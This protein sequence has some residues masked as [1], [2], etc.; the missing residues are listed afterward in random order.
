MTRI[1]T[2]AMLAA[3]TLPQAHRHGINAFA[4][5]RLLVD[6]APYPNMG[7]GDLIELFWNN[8]FAASRCL[9]ATDIGLSSHLRVPQSFVQNGTARL[10]YR[11]MQV[12]RGAARSAITRVQVKT[13]Y[14]GGQP[15]ALCGEENQNLAPVVLPE[16]IRRHGVNS[17]QIRRGV[18]LVIEPYLNMAAGDDITL[19]WGD[20]RLDLPRIQARDVS[21]RVHVWVPPALIQEAGADHRLDV[22]YCILD[23]VGNNSRW[24]PG[25]TLMLFS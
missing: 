19:R 23:R 8:C 18:P 20:S 15:S 11:V 5:S 13:D 21:H 24:A 4:A 16:M 25:L 10:H 3:P 7:K 22:T 12:G 17:R 6:I 2:P 9:Q 14:P 1:S